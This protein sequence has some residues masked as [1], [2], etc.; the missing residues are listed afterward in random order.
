MRM[1]PASAAKLK[2]GYEHNVQRILTDI[3]QRIKP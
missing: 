2:S 3:L 1:P